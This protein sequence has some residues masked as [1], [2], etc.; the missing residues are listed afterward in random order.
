MT[1]WELIGSLLL[2]IAGTFVA[3]LFAGSEMGAYSVNRVRLSLREQRPVDGTVSRARWLAKLLSIELAHPARLLGTILIGYNLASYVAAIGTTNLRG[4]LGYSEIVSVLRNTLLI[5]PVLFVLADAMPKEIFRAEADRLM[6]ALAPLLKICRVLCQITG[7]LLVIG[8]AAKL[9]EFVLPGQDTGDA[10]DP[11]ERIARM[12]KEGASSGLISDTQLGM[13]DR[14]FALR[15]VRVADEMVPWPKVKTLSAAWPRSRVLDTL[16]IKPASRY[17]L[18]NASGGLIGIVKTTDILSNP[19]A[20]LE[21]LAEEPTYV[22]PE[23]SV[24]AA[25]ITL[26][27]E[28]IRV[29]IVRERERPIGLVTAKDLVEPLTGELAGW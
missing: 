22:R 20:S 6:Y 27:A 11:R 1:N 12:I 26:K 21:S 7:A 18:L 24:R 16:G 15:E 29:A 3:A 14:A 23:Q 8:W 5:G 28:G 13:L 25:L 9:V 19:T 4:G 10:S 17:P 2:A